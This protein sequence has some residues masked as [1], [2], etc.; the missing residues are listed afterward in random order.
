LLFGG[1]RLFAHGVIQSKG[2]TTL[3]GDEAEW[4]QTF[5]R[6]IPVRE[7]RRMGGNER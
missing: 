7:T 3:G 6:G 4:G 5:V 1:F 2:R